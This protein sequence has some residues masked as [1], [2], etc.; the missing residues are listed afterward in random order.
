MDICGISILLVSTFAFVHIPLHCYGLKLLQR[1]GNEEERAALLR[2]SYFLDTGGNWEETWTARTSICPRGLL[3][4][5]IFGIGVLFL[6]SISH[7]IPQH[8]LSSMRILGHGDVFI[9][10][11]SE[12]GISVVLELYL[13]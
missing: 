8:M 3:F 12:T 13:L 9:H 2:N 5:C 10:I 4:I 11:L 6:V 7:L 1:V